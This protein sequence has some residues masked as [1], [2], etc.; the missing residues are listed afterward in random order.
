[1]MLRR[2]RRRPNFDSEPIPIIPKELESLAAYL[3]RQFKKIEERW[4]KSIEEKVDALLEKLPF[5]FGQADFY[6]QVLFDVGIETPRSTLVCGGQSESYLNEADAGMGSIESFDYSPS[7]GLMYAT[8]SP[9]DSIRASTISIDP[10]DG[11]IT[12]L[13]SGRTRHGHILGSD[14]GSFNNKDKLY[15][16]TWTGSGNKILKN[17]G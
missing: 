4:P 6:Q 12:R 14:F 3:D 17:T 10:A 16:M 13:L 2:R 1:M 7:S 8:G 9:S 11:T 15:V 5:S